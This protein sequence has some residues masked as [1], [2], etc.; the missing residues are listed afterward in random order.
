MR[1]TLWGMPLALGAI[2]C[3]GLSGVGGAAQAADA[4]SIDQDTGSLTVHKLV[5]PV[6]E[7]PAGN[8][9]EDPNVSGEPIEG[10]QFDVQPLN[11]VNLKTNEGWTSL[12]TVVD[13]FSKGENLPSGVTL[14]D[15]TSVKTTASGEA[16]FNDLPVGA[17]AV[18][19]KLTD[20]QKM[21]YTGVVPFIV[22]IPMT[23]PTQ[24][25]TWVYDVHVYPK[26]DV[27]AAEKKVVDASASDMNTSDVNFTIET[28]I[29]AGHASDLYRVEDKLDSRIQFKSATVAAGKTALTDKSDY[30]ITNAE[31]TVAMELTEQ[32][33]AKA[34]AALSS[35]ANAKVVTTLTTRVTASGE[36]DN[37]ATFYPNKAS[38]QTGG[39]PTNTVQTKFGGVKLVKQNAAQQPLEGAEFAL[40][41]GASSDFKAAT[42]IRT[43][44][45]G[46][47]G[48]LPFDG[49][50]YSAFANGASVDK[51][52]DGYA[53]YWL[54]ETKAPAGYE[55]LPQPIEVSVDSQLAAAQAISVV[56]TPSHGGGMLPR[57]GSTGFWVLVG[58]GVL[59]LVGSGLMVARARH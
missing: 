51:S 34:F 4:P 23:H 47:N 27:H 57:T 49:L 55:L 50:R 2:M 18:S 22:T 53:H 39:T 44:A 16:K 30:T 12:P 36:I 25:N 14:G 42:Q 5:Q 6:G 1:R 8:G 37:K 52:A 7:A 21:K 10:I 13:A 58:A 35:D 26:N 56:N 38:V 29:P 32:G 15:S 59:M 17:Y 31:N 40:Y 9:L 48:E 43:G 3:L 20:E 41:Y 11:G 33:R 28:S 45:T 54:V 19:E 46:K 24:L